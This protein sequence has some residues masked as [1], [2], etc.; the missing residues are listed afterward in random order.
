MAVVVI[1]G[2]TGLI[3]TKLTSHLIAE[4]H[5]VIILSRKTQQ[6]ASHRLVSYA[7]WDVKGRVIESGALLRADH[8]IHLAGA[9]IMDRKWTRDYRRQIVESRTRSAS[10]IID[11]LK[12]HPH[13]VRTFVAASAIGWY[14]PDTDP[15]IRKEGFVETD[16]AGSDFSA[17]VCMQ[18]ENASD[19]AKSLGIRLVKL[20]T[21]IV[22]SR[23][24]GAFR[25]MVAPLKF[26][27]A[28]IFGDGSQVVSWIHI[29]DLCRLYQEALFNPELQGVFNA[30]APVPVSN[31]SL[32]MTA[33]V[34][35]RNRFF[36]P[37]HVPRF[38][39]RMLLGK[40]SVEI[41]KSVTVSDRKIKKFGFTFLYPTLES[42]VADLANKPVS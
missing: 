25:E 31:R 35:L 15:L 4:G 3:G 21:G 34:K 13:H 11:V 9:G 6:P 20:R 8:I 40:R 26:G 42:A 1:S 39:I 7:H 12:N 18:W 38:F 5:E 14:G 41:L 37:V 17:E 28:G 16:P 30:V 32:M 22:L 19:E 33:A 23:D 2:G 29:D 27:V 36:I 24:G 10:L